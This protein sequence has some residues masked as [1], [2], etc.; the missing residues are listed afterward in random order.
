MDTPPKEGFWFQCP[1]TT[2]P[3]PSLSQHF[4]VKKF[5]F[6]DLSPPGNFQ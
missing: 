3:I 6:E 1:P 2:T 5:G 4:P